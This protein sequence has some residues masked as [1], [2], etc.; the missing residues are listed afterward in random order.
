MNPSKSG[1]CTVLSKVHAFHSALPRVSRSVR[2]HWRAA[3]PAPS[4][5]ICSSSSAVRVGSLSLRD[6]RG[7]VFSGELPGDHIDQIHDPADA[8]APSCQK[9]DNAG[10]GFAGHEPVYAKSPQKKCNQNSRSDKL[11]C[12]VQS[13]ILNRHARGLKAHPLQLLGGDIHQ[14]SALLG[15]AAN[16]ASLVGPVI[17]QDVQGNILGDIAQTG[18]FPFLNDILL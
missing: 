5:P 14:R 7:A 6:P 1:A 18:G 12:Y 16:N 3:A 2:R 4:G 11:I 17:S 10:S 13:F 8:K 9:P 15:G